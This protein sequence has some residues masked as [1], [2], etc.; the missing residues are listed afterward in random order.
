MKPFKLKNIATFASLVL[1]VCT[2]HADNAGSRTLM[3]QSK[4]R[5]ITPISI[6][7]TNGQGLD[8][9]VVAIGTTNSKIV[10]SASATVVANVSLGNAVVVTSVPQKAAAFTVSGENEKTY[11]ISL[12]ESMQV[13]SGSNS[14]IVDNFTCSNGATGTIGLNDLFYVGAILSVPSNAAPGSYQGTFTVTV[15]YN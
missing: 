8:F 10:V 2:S 12:P 14:L 6:V 7:N 9:G 4:A 3:T 13:L 15:S 11:A 5:V 1:F